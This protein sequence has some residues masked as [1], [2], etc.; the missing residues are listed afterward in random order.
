MPPRCSAQARACAEAAFRHCYPAYAATSSIDRLRASDYARLDQLGQVYLDYTGGGLYAATQLQKHHELLSSQVFGNPHSTNPTSQAMTHLVEQAR[1]AVLAFLNAPAAE[2]AVIF[3]PNASGAL[4]LVGEAYPFRPGGELL[5]TADNHNSV[6]GLREFARAR[7]AHFCY[8]PLRRADLRIDEEHL[9]Q[10]LGQG[11]AGAP[12]LFAYPAQSNFSGVQ[13]ALAW[14]GRAQEQGWD[15]LL[16]AAA[17]APTNRLDLSRWQPDFV[18]LSFYKIL[19]YPTGVGALVAR[20]DALARLQRPWF[21]GGTIA[22]ASVL[23]DGYVLAAG[24]AGFEDGTV[25]YLSLPAVTSGLDYL[26]RIGIDLVHTRVQCLTSWLL[27]ALGGLRHRNG[28]RLVEIHGPT[29]E[30][31]RGGTIALTL[32]DPAGQQ[33][34]ERQVEQRANDWQISLRTGCFC[35]PGAAETVRGLSAAEL[36][37]IF[38][39]AEHLTRERYQQALAGQRLGAV[40]VSLGLATTFADVDTFL[41][42]V[43]SYLD[44]PA[45]PPSPFVDQ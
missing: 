32:Y 20:R 24:E 43:R 44:R 21:A 23:G 14:I 42:F 17:F 28:A 37:P 3:T 33:A 40:R 30:Q 38:Q 27:A 35:N 6:N 25:N 1:A 31:L 39:T 34:D 10:L 36:A 13:H 16:D 22:A 4:R 5:L 9:T 8:A 26:G 19:G 7:G 12:R 41:S 15:V 18:S 2:Y 45:E 11:Q 29:N